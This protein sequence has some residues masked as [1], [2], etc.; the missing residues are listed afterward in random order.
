[1]FKCPFSAL[2]LFVRQSVF[3]WSLPVQAIL[4]DH[5]DVPSRTA[6]SA[7]SMFWSCSDWLSL[8]V[9]LFCS[10]TVFV[11]NGTDTCGWVR[12]CNKLCFFCF[13]L[14]KKCWWKNCD[15]EDPIDV[16]VV[17]VFVKGFLWGKVWKKEKRENNNYIQFEG[18]INKPY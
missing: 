10:K 13:D 5:L 3:S 18:K 16:F 15:D 1:M 14:S 6:C 17:F 9:D 11:R 4:Q 8:K 12:S 2:Y 7:L